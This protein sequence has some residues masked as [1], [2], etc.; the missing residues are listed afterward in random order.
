MGERPFKNWVLT[1]YTFES[2]D[3]E[4]VFWIAS[5]FFGFGDYDFSKRIILEYLPRKDKK[6]IWKEIKREV[7]LRAKE[8]LPME[9]K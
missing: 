1:R 2:P 5:G 9:F 4:I 8:E 7:I 3:G 6:K